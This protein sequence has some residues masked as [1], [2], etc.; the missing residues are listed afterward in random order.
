LLGDYSSDE[1]DDKPNGETMI[2]QLKNKFV[3][4]MIPYYN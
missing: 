4:E 1:E 3:I 2:K